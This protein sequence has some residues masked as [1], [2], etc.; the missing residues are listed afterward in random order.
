MPRNYYTP[1]GAFIA[2]YRVKVCAAY[3]DHD[4]VLERSR[5]KCAT[6]ADVRQ[7]AAD[8]QRKYHTGNGRN[9]VYCEVLDAKGYYVPPSVWNA[10]G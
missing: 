4:E 6:F 7:C 3:Y 8:L 9:R 10:Q 5:R 2:P 1:T